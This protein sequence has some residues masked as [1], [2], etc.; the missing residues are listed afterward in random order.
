M[1]TSVFVLQKG[2]KMKRVFFAAILAV[3]VCGCSSQYMT[4]GKVYVQKEEYEK[5]IE[6]FNIQLEQTPN[7]GDALWWLGCVYSYKKDYEKA[8]GYFDKLRETT[9]EKAELTKEKYFLWTVYYNSGLDAL[10]KENFEVAKKRFGTATLV[11]PDSA[12]AYINLAQAYSKT[13]NEDSMVICYERASKVAPKNPDICMDLAAYYSKEKNYDK[14]M[15]QLKK[16]LELNPKNAELLYR[17]GVIYYLKED[18]SNSESF[19]NETIKQDSTYSDAYFNLSASLVKEKKFKPAIDV[20]Q[21]YLISKPTD[22]EALS[23]LGDLYLLN[24]E[25]KLAVDIYTKLIEI[26]SSNPLYY[27]NRANAYWKTG[28]KE[29]NSADIKKAQEL[30][31]K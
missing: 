17:L 18:Y 22:T 14:A 4:A 11:E 31:K 5:A 16:A 20:L 10:K 8:C 15:E 6:Q 28:D 26:D 3:L 21:K 29:K 7:D 30:Q 1:A 2:G 24:Q 25:Y 19:F 27:E 23:N 9:P 12:S 13:G